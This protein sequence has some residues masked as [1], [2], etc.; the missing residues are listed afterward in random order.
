MRISI[1]GA[2]YVGLVTGACL[3]E[4]GHH[5]ICV[6]VDAEKVDRINRGLP[7]IYEQQLG[8][9]LKKNI[10]VNLRASTDLRQS[11]IETDV[12]FISVGTPF[13][14]QSIDLTHVK[15]AAVHIGRALNEK[16][17]YHLVV[18]KST[19]VPGTTDGVMLP[20]LE[21]ASGKK[22]GRDF[23]VGMNPE[24]LTEGQAVQDFMFPDRLVL[25]GIDDKSISV[26]EEIY[27]GFSGVDVIRTN[28]KTAE[29]IKYVS[30]CLLATMIS[31]SNE[32]A[33]LCSALGNVDSVD[34]MQGVHLSNYLSSRLPTGERVESPITSFLVAGCGY[35]GSCLPKDLKALIA[36][37]RTAG[38]P[39]VLLE[40]VNRVNERQLGRI[41]SLLEEHFPSLKG[42]RISVLGLSFRPDTS[43]MRESPAIPLISALVDGGAIV[44]AYDPV[45]KGEAEEVFRGCNLI[46]CDALDEAVRGAD[47]IVLLTRWDEFKRVP[48][49]LAG[50]DVQPLVVDG[51][52]MLHKKSIKRYVGIG[53]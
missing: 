45:A 11:V 17:T 36:H 18:V 42:I 37:G 9:L 15:E 51:R 2:G 22:A 24:F 4:K 5:V 25:G 16:A 52:R 38:T 30:N 8:D 48:S 32:I 26:L 50:L 29:M 7:P 27:C 34:V 33:N 1:V 41:L 6:D 3:A 13:D 35:G 47:A 28:T 43:D 23:G 10:P 39:M 20:I 40:A 21:K 53:L 49:L 46:L 44:K 14:G 31:F 19:V 12:S